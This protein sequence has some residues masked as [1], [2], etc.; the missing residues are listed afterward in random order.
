MRILLAIDSLV[1]GGRERRMLGLLKELA[2]Q[3]DVAVELV[4]FSRKIEYPDVYQIGVPIHL[5]ERVP[6]KD[7]RVFFRF[8]R[9]CKKFRP[10]IV[11]T[12]GTMSAVYAVP[13]SQLARIPLINDNIADAPG[14]MSWLDSRLWRAKLTYPFSSVVIGNSKAGLQS[15]RAPESKSRCI[16][17][18]FN[19]ARI[20]VLEDPTSVRLRLGLPAAC[21]VVGMV[22]AFFDRKDYPAFLQSA[23]IVLKKATNVAFLAIGDGPELPTCMASIPEEFKKSILFT[24]QVNDVESIINILDIGVLSTNANVHGE[25]ISN[26]IIEYMILKKPVVATDG[27]GT[28]EIVEN[29]RTGFIVPP[30][31]PEV[32]AEKIQY[33]LDH[34]DTAARMGEAGAAKIR[35]GFLLSG[36]MQQYF[37]VYK[38]IMRK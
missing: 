8:Y 11:H 25:G 2:R 33:L 1:K 21:R 24:G 12:W 19:L 35:S 3:P 16:Y 22:G 26:S 37:Q 38:H 5:L 6:R 30:F 10:D 29:E 28:P 34:P 13:T 32:M 18:G 4:V 23:Q 7:P 36:M 17:N 27:G 15:Y 31:S 14:N 9:I 20:A